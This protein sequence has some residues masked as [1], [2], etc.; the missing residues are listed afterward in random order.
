MTEQNDICPNLVRPQL[1]SLQPA[2][3]AVSVPM[4][5]EN[6]FA[7]AFP[8]HLPRH[9]GVVI[10]IAAY[11]DDVHVHQAAQ[12]VGVLD[13]VTEMDDGVH[14]LCQ[15]VGPQRRVEITVGIGHYQDFHKISL[16]E[17]GGSD[18]LKLSVQVVHA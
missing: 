1:Q 16:A 5:Q 10:A 15:A 4:R 8:Q 2:L 3:D 9:R 6:P 14:G 11:G 18:T 12:Q 13:P 7:F 17:A